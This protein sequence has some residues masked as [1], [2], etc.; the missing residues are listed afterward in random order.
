MYKCRVSCE[1]WNMKLLSIYYY[2]FLQLSCIKSYTRRPICY[3]LYCQQNSVTLYSVEHLL[4][5]N[6]KIE[7]YKKQTHFMTD[8]IFDTTLSPIRLHNIHQLPLL[9]WYSDRDVAHLVTLIH[10]KPELT[11]LFNCDFKLGCSRS[12][13]TINQ[14]PRLEGR[15]G[16]GKVWK[17]EGENWA[18]FLLRFK[19]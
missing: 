9:Y 1:R 11:V 8:T 10:S 4:A 14:A 6:H 3:S 18:Y 17:Y 5:P 15:G 12:G 2:S 19:E 7:Q 13:I 16:E